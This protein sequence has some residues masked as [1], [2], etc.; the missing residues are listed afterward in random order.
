MWWRFKRI[1][2]ESLIL[3][4]LGAILFFSNLIVNPALS[5]F[6]FKATLISAGIVHGHL[7]R[8]FFF[9]YID[10]KNSTDPYHKLLVIVLYAVVLLAW[11]NAG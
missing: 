3:V 11:S 1:F 6:C 4:V 5:L 2:I 9:P 7:I 10:F 8:K